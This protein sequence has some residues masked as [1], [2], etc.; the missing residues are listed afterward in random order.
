M[1]VCSPEPSGMD[2]T[3]CWT[4]DDVHKSYPQ[5]SQASG[6]LLG[7]QDVCHCHSC[8]SSPTPP[9]VRGDPQ[10]DEVGGGPPRALSALPSPSPTSLSPVRSR[11]QTAN[12]LLAEDQ[13]P[14]Q[15]RVQLHTR[16]AWSH[17]DPRALNASSKPV[18][19]CPRREL[20]L[21]SHQK[22][23]TRVLNSA[24]G[25]SQKQM[26]QPVCPSS[27]LSE[28]VCPCC[29]RPVAQ[30]PAVC[31]GT[32]L[33]TTERPEGVG[34]GLRSSVVRVPGHGRALRHGGRKGAKSGG[35]AWGTRT[36]VLSAHL[37]RR[38]GSSSVAV[39]LPRV[40]VFPLDAV[41]ASGGVGQR[42]RAETNPKLSCER[43]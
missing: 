38:K 27:A 30:D 12:G 40:L 33:L 16:S 17:A 4:L 11:R 41:R 3:P 9:A 2:S 10:W 25:R 34:G 31:G 7:P 5:R 21:L 43:A 39:P 6:H 24:E 20:P 1:L 37:L 32:C 28:N 14:F 19:L 42:G 13:G 29:P 8:V 23:L 22:S 36:P 26:V 35:E 15:S 18:H